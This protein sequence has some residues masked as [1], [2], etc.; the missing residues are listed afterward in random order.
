LAAKLL[1]LSKA[2]ANDWSAFA[3]AVEDG[4]KEA[5]VSA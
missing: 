5:T 1:E 4:G 3:R 2:M